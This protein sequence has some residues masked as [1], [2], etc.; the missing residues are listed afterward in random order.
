MGC[1]IPLFV[2]NTHLGLAQMPAC[3]YLKSGLATIK[4]S[5]QVTGTALPAPG[6]LGASCGC[7]QEREERVGRSWS[8]SPA[9]KTMLRKSAHIIYAFVC[10]LTPPQA[11]LS[12]GSAI[13]RTR[14]GLRSGGSWPPGLLT[15]AQSMQNKGEWGLGRAPMTARILPGCVW[16]GGPDEWRRLVGCLLVL[17]PL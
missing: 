16:D 7:S 9:Q 3:S 8:A 13:Q 14:V 6:I 12:G 1:K 5:A 2:S 15:W 4:V 10:S 17:L 11:G